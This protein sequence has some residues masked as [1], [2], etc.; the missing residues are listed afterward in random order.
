MNARLGTLL[1]QYFIA[2][3]KFVL[4]FLFVVA[5]GG[6]RKG[7]GERQSVEGVRPSNKID[8]LSGVV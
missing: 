3:N 4:S 5:A 2:K 7:T 6:G 1:V 8:F